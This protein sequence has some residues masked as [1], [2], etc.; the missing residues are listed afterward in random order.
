MG[1]AIF[2]SHTRL[3]IAYV[4]SLVSQFMHNPSEYHMKEVMQI[5]R[6]F[7]SSS[8]KGLMFRKHNHL[9]IHGYTN[10]D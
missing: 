7:K 3:D 8:C 10:T 5:L 2:L 6:Y 9:N 1:K 4:V